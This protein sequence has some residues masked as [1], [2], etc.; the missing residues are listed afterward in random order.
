[1]IS[2]DVYA[3]FRS[4]AENADPGYEKIIPIANKYIAYYE[5]QKNEQ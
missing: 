3:F 5:K 1:M 2:K 4:V